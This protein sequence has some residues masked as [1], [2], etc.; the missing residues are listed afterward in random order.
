MGAD[1]DM[2][3]LEYEDECRLRKL[4]ML[5]EQ[6]VNQ[7]LVGAVR[8][9]YEVFFDDECPVPE[10]VREFHNKEKAEEQVCTEAEKERRK[11]R[12]PEGIVFPG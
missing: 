10:V 9:Y 8:A 11:R 5:H 1:E 12:K 2:N 4:A 7:I 3:R 6:P